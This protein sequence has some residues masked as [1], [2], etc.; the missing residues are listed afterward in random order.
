MRKLIILQTLGLL[1]STA[2]LHAYW[3][4]KEGKFL[5]KTYELQQKNTE[6]H[7]RPI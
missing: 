1:L 2:L 4:N 6:E 5:F 7:G 3:N